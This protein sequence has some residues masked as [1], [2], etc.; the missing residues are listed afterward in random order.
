VG[1][2]EFRLLRSV[3]KMG[4]CNCPPDAEWN[5]EL[6]CTRTYCRNVDPNEKAAQ[7]KK[8]DAAARHYLTARY[9]SLQHATRVLKKYEGVRSKQTTE[10]FYVRIARWAR[11][12]PLPTRA[13]ARLRKAA[14]AAAG[15]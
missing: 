7:D 8:N 14:K 6:R 2:S 5:P 9:G 10:S 4:T 1:N 15:V 12:L 13:S 11:A 3:H